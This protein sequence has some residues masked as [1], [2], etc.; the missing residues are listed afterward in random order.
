MNKSNKNFSYGI[1]YKKSVSVED[2]KKKNSVK[3]TLS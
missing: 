1:V 2:K 3:E